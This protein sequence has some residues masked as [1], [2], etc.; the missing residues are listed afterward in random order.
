MMAAALTIYAIFVALII[1]PW[2]GL[3]PRPAVRSATAPPQDELRSVLA[4][5]LV[6]PSPVD[7]SNLAKS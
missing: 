2:M 3:L 5:K 7:L 4:R 6:P 1:Q